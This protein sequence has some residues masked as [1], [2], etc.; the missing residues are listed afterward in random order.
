[1]I[2]HNI[3]DTFLFYKNV[4]VKGGEVGLY[5][6][7]LGITHKYTFFIVKALGDEKYGFRMKYFFNKNRFVFL[8]FYF[9][10]YTLYTLLVISPRSHP[11]S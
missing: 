2:F 11:T 9:W 7:L 5:A 8:G 4:H 3:C 1:M 6:W 10:C